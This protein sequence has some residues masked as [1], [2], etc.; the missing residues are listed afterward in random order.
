MGHWDYH[1]LELFA[2]DPADTVLAVL[3]PTYGFHSNG[4]ITYQA[5]AWL[6]CGW[7]DGNAAAYQALVTFCQRTGR[8]WITS[9]AVDVRATLDAAFFGNDPP[10]R[11]ARLRTLFG[12]PALFSEEE[13]PH[14]D[15]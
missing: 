2:H 1:A 13:H 6:H 9:Y 14:P 15:Q 11:A 12:A 7:D 4:V 5:C 3:P 8:R 10:Q